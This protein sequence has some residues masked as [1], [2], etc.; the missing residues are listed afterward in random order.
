M[1]STDIKKPDPD[2]RKRIRSHVMLG[3][4][5]GKTNALRKGKRRE[6]QDT[7]SSTSDVPL[8]SSSG[9]D[10]GLTGLSVTDT[11]TFQAVVPVKVPCRFGSDVST[12]RF[13]DAVAPETVEVVLNCELFARH[14]CSLY[15][16][17]I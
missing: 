11:T 4:N 10:K 3:K 14:L 6:D 12:I 8:S 5:L 15:A 1:V 2:L 7:V 17:L 13:A 16:R 9:S